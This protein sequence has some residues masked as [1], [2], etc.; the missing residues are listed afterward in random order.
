[1]NVAG[2]PYVIE[3]NVR[4]GDPETEAIVP[5]IE[6]DLVELLTAAANQTLDTAPLQISTLAAATV[7]LVAEGY[8]GNYQ[9]GAVISGLPQEGNAVDALVFHAGTRQRRNAG[10]HQRGAGAGRHR[11]GRRHSRSAAPM[12]QNGRAN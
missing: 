7:V 10:G 3:Y 5:R 12:L 9:K 1:M 6:S 4:L 8:P 2:E 11:P